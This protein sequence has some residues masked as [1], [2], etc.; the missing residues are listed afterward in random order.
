VQPAG[1]LPFELPSSMEAARA[2]LPDVP[3]DS[4]APLYPYG[5]G[6]KSF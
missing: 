6:L 1:K 4:E 2:Q 3:H 5:H